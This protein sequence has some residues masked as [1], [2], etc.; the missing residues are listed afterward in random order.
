MIGD[1]NAFESSLR[2][3]GTVVEVQ[4]AEERVSRRGVPVSKD[5]LRRGES[6][7]RR[8]VIRLALG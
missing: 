2:G 1:R 4:Y 3:D 5:D 7:G 6:R 8:R